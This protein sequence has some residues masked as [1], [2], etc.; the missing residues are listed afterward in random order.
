MNFRKHLYIQIRS[1][2]IKRGRGGWV[3]GRGILISVLT[4]SIPEPPLSGMR[5]FSPG[6][7]DVDADAADD[8]AA[9][10]ALMAAVFSCS[11][12][13][14]GGEGVATVV[15]VGCGW[16]EARAAGAGLTRL[17]VETL[18]VPVNR[19]LTMSSCLH[20]LKLRHSPLML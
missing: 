9:A 12:T 2:H 17:P 10:A 13:G 5:T 15:V 11:A 18:T 6:F 7:L 3:G 1:V 19:Q 16:G 20:D 4:C 8:E 14:T